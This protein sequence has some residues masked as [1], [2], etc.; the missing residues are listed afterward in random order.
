VMKIKGKKMTTKNNR[1][2][3]HLHPQRM[4]ISDK[5]MKVIRMKLAPETRNQEIKLE[6]KGKITAQKSPMMERNIGL[7]VG[8]QQG[9][10]R[11]IQKVIMIGTGIKGRVGKKD[12]RSW[13]SPR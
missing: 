3:T 13:I 8:P 1:H 6:R 7:N 4:R 11:E 5:A 12:V 2:Q 10:E 9:T